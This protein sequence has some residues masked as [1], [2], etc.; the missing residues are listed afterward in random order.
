[1]KGVGG[2]RSGEG[3]EVEMRSGEG[4]EVEMRSGEGKEG[5]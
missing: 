3:K 1:V 5:G 2:M 4:K